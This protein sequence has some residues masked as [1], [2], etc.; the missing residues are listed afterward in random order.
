[1]SGRKVK[2]GITIGD[3]N[4][5]GPEIIMKTFNEPMMYNWCTPV[6]YGSSRILHYHK[7]FLHLDKFYYESITDLSQINPK[8]LNVVECWQEEVII[9]LGQP[10]QKAGECALLA[11]DE[12][13]KDLLAKKIDALVTAPVNKSLIKPKGKE[14][15]GHTSYITQRCGLSE[16][17]MLL[18]SEELRVGL[19]TEH[20]ALKEVAGQLSVKKIV[21]KLEILHQSLHKDFGIMKPRIAVLSL[22]PHS[23]EG[24][25]TGTEEKEIILPAIQKAQESGILAWGPYPADGL[26]ATGAYKKFDVLLAMYHDQGL[27]PF[28]FV[29]FEHGVNFTAGLP[30]IRTSPDHGTA[31]DLAG[32]NKANPSSF[33]EAVL[34]AADIFRHRT[35]YEVY[36]AN[37]LKA[38]Q[39]E[40]EE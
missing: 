18:I 28:K 11:L 31:Y 35:D 23:G 13:L 40:Q 14:F 3:F 39:L 16:S 2:V 4:G 36:A 19:V 15:T 8:T 21:A 20:I 29:A 22:N 9:N 37:P 7:Q 17:V 12:A 5:I 38:K 6:L 1:M 25:L 10:S 32:K 24:G 30:V 33:R 27:V 34:V 26:F